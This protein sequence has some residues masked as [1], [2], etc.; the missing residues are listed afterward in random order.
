M[1]ITNTHP[2][3]PDPV[4]HVLFVCTGN[5]SRS[6]MAAAIFRHL[7]A[8]QGIC[9]SVD[10]AGTDA[11]PGFKPTK[12][13]LQLL[14]EHQILHP[15]HKAKKCNGDLLQKSDVVFVME[16]YH[17]EKLLSNHPEM[18]KKI[19]LLAEFGHGVEPWIRDM[20]IPDPVGMNFSFYENVYR[21]IDGSCR[22][23]LQQILKRKS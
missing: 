3:L 23:I 7:L 6:V 4:E 12:H 10:S 18:E 2:S 20:G 21:L 16:N 9:L 22:N 5:C 14:K 13:T 17:R 15:D 11:R 19:F 1:S 8:L